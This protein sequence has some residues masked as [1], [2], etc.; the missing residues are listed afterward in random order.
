M[1][2]PVSWIFLPSLTYILLSGELCASSWCKQHFS[3][4]DAEGPWGESKGRVAEELFVRWREQAGWWVPVP[5]HCWDCRLG[6]VQHYLR[7]SGQ[8]TLLWWRTGQPAC[9]GMWYDSW[10]G[11]GE[12]NLAVSI[13]AKVNWE[14]Y[15]S[16]GIEFRVVVNIDGPVVELPF[17]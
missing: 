3:Q 6:V 12:S 10:I 16:L 7:V 14:T 17:C 4:A 2:G 5:R 15:Q 9:L 1:C 8:P 11:W 13:T